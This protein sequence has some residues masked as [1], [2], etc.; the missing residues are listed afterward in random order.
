MKLLT[1]RVLRSVILQTVRVMKEIWP[2]RECEEQRF[3]RARLFG[4]VILHA[5]PG[6]AGPGL[7]KIPDQMEDR[8]INPD[9]ISWMRKIEKFLEIKKILKSRTDRGW[10]KIPD[11][12]WSRF[13][14]K[15]WITDRAGR[16]LA[17]VQECGL[18]RP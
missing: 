16:R 14:T 10:R 6:T 9:Q 5:A 15:V 3:C 2:G 1:A 11:L 12:L 18:T 8:K 4:R 17:S 7:P 13:Y